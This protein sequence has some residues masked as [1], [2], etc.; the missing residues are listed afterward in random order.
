MVEA[1]VEEAEVEA[2]AGLAGAGS[3]W[4]SMLDP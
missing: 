4:S 1:V 3:S 2:G